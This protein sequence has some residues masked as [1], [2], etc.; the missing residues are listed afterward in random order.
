MMLYRQRDL[1]LVPVPFSDLTSRK[2]RPVVVLSNARYNREGPD[3]LVAG[4]TSNVSSRAYTVILDTAQLEE[5]TMRCASV[6]RADKV[7]S[8]D[9]GIVL[10]RVGRVSEPTFEQIRGQLRDLLADVS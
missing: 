6:V 7:F 9:Q 10:K 2:I 1:L 3:L 5:G 8:I 4:V